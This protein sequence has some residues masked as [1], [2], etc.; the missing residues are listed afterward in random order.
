MIWPT[1]EKTL[2]KFCSKLEL[3]RRE[4]AQLQPLDCMIAVS[5]YSENLSDIQ[6]MKKEVLNVWNTEK[7]QDVCSC[8]HIR[9]YRWNT[10]KMTFSMLQKQLQN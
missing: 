2:W 4:L 10:G 3:I 6:Q 9:I 5:H 1:E 8:F 7:I